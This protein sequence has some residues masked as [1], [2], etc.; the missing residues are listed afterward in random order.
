MVGLGL[1]AKALRLRGRR[2]ALVAAAKRDLDRDNLFTAPQTIDKIHEIDG[3]I[4][5]LE[6][7]A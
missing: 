2:E 7:T 5:G 6:E 1:R 3:E 4:R